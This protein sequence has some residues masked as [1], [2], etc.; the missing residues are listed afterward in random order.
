[1]NF[2]SP[3]LILPP[4]TIDDRPCPHK[5][6]H[7]T[8]DLLPVSVYVASENSV[9][10]LTTPSGFPDILSSY[11]PKNLRVIKEDEPYHDRVKICYYCRK[12]DKKICNKKIRFYCST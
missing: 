2:G 6:D 10:T 7:Y 4:I 8:S 9:S 3:D 1:M 5:R 11:V 12:H